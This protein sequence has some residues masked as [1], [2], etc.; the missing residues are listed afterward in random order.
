MGYKGLG[1]LAYKAL[2][3]ERLGWEEMGIESQSTGP[4]ASKAA[5]PGEGEGRCVKMVQSE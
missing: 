5:N 2:G 1:S 4:K 3:K